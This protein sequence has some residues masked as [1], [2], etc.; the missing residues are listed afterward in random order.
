MI[1]IVWSILTYP[2]TKLGD[3]ESNALFLAAVY[4]DVVYKPES[5]TNEKDSVSFMLETLKQFP[6]S[7]VT[8]EVIEKASKLILDTADLDCSNI[9]NYYDRQFIINEQEDELLDYSSKI[10]KEFNF[11]S[12][13]DFKKGHLEIVTKINPQLRFYKNFLDKIRPRVGLYVGSFNPLHIGHKF[14]ADEASKIFDKVILASGTNPDKVNCATYSTGIL[15]STVFNRYQT[16]S[17]GG[18]LSNVVSELERQYDV[19]IVRGVRN[20]QDLEYGRMQDVF[21]KKI[22]PDIKVVYINSPSELSHISSSAIKNLINLGATDV[23]KEM[24]WI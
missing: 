24:L 13:E 14:I 8:P 10:W 17:F 23:A 6:N 3:V 20:G 15:S 22:K 16:I 7:L 19:T 5:N 21:L 4:H 2:K 11:H 1:S 12:W 9:L 18:L